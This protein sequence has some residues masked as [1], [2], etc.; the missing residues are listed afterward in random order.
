MIK[1]TLLIQ[2]CIQNPLFLSP[3]STLMVDYVLFSKL[4]FTQHRPHTGS[5][6]SWIFF[7]FFILP[8]IPAKYWAHLCVSKSTS[9]VAFMFSFSLRVPDG[10]SLSFHSLPNRDHLIL[11]LFMCL[12]P[13][14]DHVHLKSDYMDAG[15]KLLNAILDL[16][17]NGLICI[18]VRL[19][20]LGGTDLLYSW[21]AYCWAHCHTPQI[22]NN[23]QWPWTLFSS[24][25]HLIAI[26]LCTKQVSK[27]W[28]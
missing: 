10:I 25:F 7:A 5:S 17:L 16:S 23:E 13:S 21:C 14:K 19:Q 1:I 26:Y 2:L 4:C 18:C 12:H 8:K 27:R 22:A 9:T 24:A 3:F 28:H 11:G 6:L 15:K 20:A